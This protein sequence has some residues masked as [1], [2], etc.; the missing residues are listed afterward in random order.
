MI[1]TARLLLFS[2]S[3]AQME[4]AISAE[5][6][7]E[8]QAAYAEMLAGCLEHPDQWEWYAMWMI[9]R[10]DGTQVGDLCFKGL[11]PDATAEIGYGILEAHQGRGYATEAVQAATAW[12]LSHPALRAVEAETEAKQPGL[13]AGSGQVRLSAHRPGRRGGPALCLAAKNRAVRVSPYKTVT[14]LSSQAIAHRPELR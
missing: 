13:P 9:E 6:S 10:K 4:A 1:E 2:A 11:T 3:W 5:P 14:R 7:A 8:L 12:A